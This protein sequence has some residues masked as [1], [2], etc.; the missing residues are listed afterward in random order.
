MAAIDNYTML[1][2]RPKK[3]SNFA[4]W[5]CRWRDSAV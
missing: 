2:S 4:F 5:P 3:D 1:T